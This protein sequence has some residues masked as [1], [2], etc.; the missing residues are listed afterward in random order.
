MRF[1]SPARTQTMTELM[2]LN[3]SVSDTVDRSTTSEAAVQSATLIADEGVLPPSVQTIQNTQPSYPT[4]RSVSPL[5]ASSANYAQ[6]VR[7]LPKRETSSEIDEQ[8]DFRSATS[9]PR[10][11]TDSDDDSDYRSGVVGRVPQQHSSPRVDPTLRRDYARDGLFSPRATSP[12]SPGEL[13]LRSRNVSGRPM[14]P[15]TDF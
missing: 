7:Q 2:P 5:A 4:V 1:I 3:N 14:S 9:L 11:Q 6:V 15:E 10:G 12:E 8:L 13:P